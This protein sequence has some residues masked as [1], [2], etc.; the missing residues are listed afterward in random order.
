MS[1]AL[2]RRR[3]DTALRLVGDA[4]AIEDFHEGSA[5]DVKVE[6]ERL[7]AQILLVELH[8]SRNRQVVAAVDLGPASES[9]E[10]DMN[11]AFG[12]QSDEILL[13]KES[14]TGPDE[15]HVSPEN[16]EQLWQFVETGTA[17]KAA[18]GGKV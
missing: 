7:A 17:Q 11:S 16:A 9:G 18:D 13:I 5:Q 8:L 6:A 1:E 4:L 10:Q 12:A 2:V 14:G 15:A 3:G